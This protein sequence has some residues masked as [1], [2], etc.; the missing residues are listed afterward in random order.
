MS[1]TSMLPLLADVSPTK[2]VIAAFAGWL[3]WLDYK[4]ASISPKVE[5]VGATS[6]PIPIIG[7]WIAAIRFLRDPVKAVREGTRKTKNGMFKITTHQGEY[8]LVTDRAKV[9]EYLR[10]PD[11]V[12]SMQD[13]ANDQQQIPFTMGYG[14]GHRTYHTSVVKGP[15]TKKINEKTPDMIDEA[16]LALDELFGA[17][18]EYTPFPLYDHMAMVVARI[19]NRIYVGTRFC[20]NERY[21]RAAID[22]AQYVV[23]SAELIRVL[24]DWLKRI[25]V[26]YMPC[27]TYRKMAEVYLADFIRERLEERGDESDDKPDDLLQWLVDAAPPIEKTVPQLS[28][29]L[30][31][32]NVG[33]IHTRVMTFTGAPYIL[34]ENSEKYTAMLREEV[35]ASLVDGRI[36]VESLNKL[37]KMDSFLR[38]SARCSNLGMLNS[39]TV[40]M[41]RNARQQFTFS[42]GTVIPKGAKVGSP[43]LITHY[44]PEVY[45]NPEVFDPL[46][47]YNEAREHGTAQKTILTTGPNFNVFGAG[48]HP[49]PGRFL[50]THEM[51]II[52]SMLLLRYDFKFADGVKAKPL[53]I[54]TMSLPDTMVN[55]LFRRRQV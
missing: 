39:P 10:A 52:L 27:T 16:S 51:K 3:L 55:V 32:L 47:W 22:Y 28:E 7:S 25:V 50:A 11:D 31:A 35:E 45:A 12:L 34:A 42:D 15:V 8:V 29:R 38:E 30:M 49:C 54:A 9:S 44:D 5:P 41:Q 48:R 53:Y 23:I 37:P 1:T 33:S 17:P 14:V 13:G 4:R 2:A 6:L 19:A 40:A 46:R 43:T 36:A 20:R 26:P 21:L 18:E 24:P